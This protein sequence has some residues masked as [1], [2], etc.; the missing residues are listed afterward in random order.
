ME[1]LNEPDEYSTNIPSC[2]F[3]FIEYYNYYDP[4]MMPLRKQKKEKDSPSPSKFSK[5]SAQSYVSMYSEM[6]KSRYS[7][8]PWSD[9]STPTVLSTLKNS[10]SLVTKEEKS[11][12]SSTNHKRPHSPQKVVA[13]KGLSLVKLKE[14]IQEIYESKEKYDQRCIDSKIPIETMEQHVQTYLNWQYGLKSIIAGT[15]SLRTYITC[16]RLVTSTS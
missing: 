13:S 3:L 1:P 11:T 5:T 8:M 4:D 16:N 12:E 9:A 10:N 7:T 15:K 6:M 2:I 14:I